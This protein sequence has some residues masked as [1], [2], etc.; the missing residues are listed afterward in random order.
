MYAEYASIAARPYARATW[1]LLLRK[2]QRTRAGDASEPNGSGSHVNDL[3]KNDVSRASD[4]YEFVTQVKPLNI[5]TLLSNAPMLYVRG[6]TLHCKDDE[7]SLRYE[8]RAHK[9]IAIVLTGW[10]GRITIGAMRFCTEFGKAIIVLDRGRDLTTVVL[11]PAARSEYI[12]RAQLGANK[13][14][15]A[16]SIISAKIKAHFNVGAIDEAG[17]VS[18]T[19]AN[20]NYRRHTSTYDD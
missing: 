18:M 20:T 16:Q 7:L 12:L 5:L 2:Q 3:H 9:P 10:G 6:D 11:T 8:K 13:L 14:N 15:V 4:Y 19:R 1:E 17:G